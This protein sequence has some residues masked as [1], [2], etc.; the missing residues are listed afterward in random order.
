M[1]R[2]CKCLIQA[3]LGDHNSA[4]YTVSLGNVRSQLTK[5]CIKAHE[6]DYCD[7]YKSSISLLD[8]TYKHLN[9]FLI[10]FGVGRAGFNK[11]KPQ[12][13]R[14]WHHLQCINSNWPPLSPLTVLSLHRTQLLLPRGGSM[15]CSRFWS[16]S[17]NEP[18]RRQSLPYGIEVKDLHLS[19]PDVPKTH[20]VH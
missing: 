9:C 13:V 1:L 10:S 3:Y 18:Q 8:F 5:G 11:Q 2:S 15:L 20:T 12:C 14:S 19:K 7:N 17:I 4:P 6:Q 16:S